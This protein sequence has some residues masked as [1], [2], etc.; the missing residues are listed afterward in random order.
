MFGKYDLLDFLEREAIPYIHEEHDPVLNMSDSGRLALSLEGA[1][2]KNLLLQDKKGN[3]FLVVTT[4]TKSLD[5]AAASIVL[6]SKRL[7]FASAD[8][9]WDLLGIRAGA[10]SPFA[11]L[12]DSGK[13]VRLVIDDELS[14][15]QIFLFHPLENNSSVSITQATLEDFLARIGHSADWLP[16]PGRA[17]LQ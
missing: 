15:Q 6:E 17:A 10:L 3:H 7:S 2:C 12:N 9:L 13:K 4:A 8:K 1:R 14:G 5:L 11:L 16:L